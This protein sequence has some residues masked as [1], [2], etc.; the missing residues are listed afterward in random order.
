MLPILLKTARPRSRRLVGAVRR[1]ARRRHRHR[2]LLPGRRPDPA[3]H[4]ALERPPSASF[5]PFGNRPLGVAGRL[6][7]DRSRRGRASAQARRARVTDLTVGPCPRSLA[8]RPTGACGPG[9]TSCSE[10]TRGNPGTQSD[11]APSLGASRAARSPVTRAGGREGRQAP[12]EE[13]SINASR[14]E[15]FVQCV[16]CAGQGRLLAAVTLLAGCGKSVVGDR[17]LRAGR[18]RQRG[19]ARDRAGRRVRGRA[20]HRARR[21]QSSGGTG[22]TVTV[23]GAAGGVVEID[24][25]GR[26]VLAGLP[27]GAVTLRIEG[28]GV[29]RAGDRAGARGRAGAH[30]RDEAHRRHGS[31]HRL[32]DL[33][34]ERVGRVLLRRHRVDLADADRRVAARGGR[35]EA[36]EGLEAERPSAAVRPRGRATASRSGARF[37]ATASSWPT[38]SCR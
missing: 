10:Q 15:P 14:G 12:L 31:A 22:Y 13:A 2:H 21:T 7:A 33:R 28:A 3:R 8:C 36:A 29:E 6:Y 17:Q 38:R 35:D 37:A 4:A 25:D 20:R 16:P 30:G 27:A 1:D 11:G 18:R 23:V 26:F 24:E 5:A 19:A 32:A 9:T 34:A